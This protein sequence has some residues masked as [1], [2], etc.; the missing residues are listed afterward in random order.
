MLLAQE[1]PMTKY[2]DLKSLYEFLKLKNTPKKHWSDSLGW[3]IE[4]YVHNQILAT[5]KVVI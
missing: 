5:S 1:K 4:E 2:K 3:E